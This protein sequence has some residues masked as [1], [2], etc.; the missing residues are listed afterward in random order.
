MKKSLVLGL[1]ILFTVAANAQT[2][3]KLGWI[4]ANELLTV[5]PERKVAAAKLDSIV[6]VE[7]A[8][9]KILKDDYERVGRLLQAAPST[10]PQAEYDKLMDEFNRIQ[11]GLYIQQQNSQAKVADEEKK[12]IDPI[13]DK[14]NEAIK[15][16]GKDNGYT[17][18][19]DISLGQV[20]VKPE[21]DNI[22][23]LV[24]KELGLPVMD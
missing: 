18:I 12:L 21:G 19:F 11:D 2:K 5:M 8:V 7:E 16:V 9:L 6:K 13:L 3:I 1:F 4:D 15:K 24:K 22:L 23:K 20:L 17:Y 10:M 14:I